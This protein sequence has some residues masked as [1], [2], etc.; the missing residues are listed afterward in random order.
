MIYKIREWRPGLLIP[1]GPEPDGMCSPMLDPF[2]HEPWW[3]AQSYDGDTLVWSGVKRR[4]VDIARNDVRARR[5]RDGVAGDGV[6]GD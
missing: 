1:F 3:Q 6:S 5:L 4:S 2:N